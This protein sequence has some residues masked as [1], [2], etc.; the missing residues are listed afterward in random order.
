MKPKAFIA[1][2]VEGLPYAYAIQQ[3]LE[4]DAECTVWSQGVFTPSA[5][6]IE[7][8]VEELG[9]SDFG[10][11]VFTADDVV[12]LRD[13]QKKAVRDNVLFELGMFIGRLERRRNFIVHPRGVE[14]FHWPSD[15]T[16]LNPV[17]FDP[18]RQDKNV[19]AALGTACNQIREAIKKVGPVAPTVE[20]VVAELNDACLTVSALFGG[21][22][23]FS[24]PPAG[25]IDSH[26]FDEGLRRLQSLKCLRFDVSADGKKFAYHWTDIGKLILQKF[27][28][29]KSPVPTEGMAPQPVQNQRIVQLSAE[30]GELLAQAVQDTSG[31][32]F[33]VQ[34]S[35]GFHIQTNQQSFGD[36]RNARS[37]A[38]WKAALDELFGVGIIEPYGHKG[39]M[40]QVTDR[41]YKA[42][43]QIPPDFL[44]KVKEKRASESLDAEE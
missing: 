20:K 8:I 9:R 24:R 4:Y 11:F 44:E 27:G 26:L 18:N 36:A 19:T 13:E 41:G 42:A 40:F 6:P 22:P 7:D 43:D 3:N 17:T 5:Y 2:S 34:S 14:D 16:G 10:V 29:D 38:Q 32:I 21:T 33:A 35:E 1:S 12:M 30:A 28:Y 25:T 37:M 23:F 39:E 31:L 15:L